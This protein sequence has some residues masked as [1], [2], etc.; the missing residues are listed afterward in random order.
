MS[1]VISNIKLNDDYY[2]IKV[3]KENKSTPGQFY[4]L[5]SWEEYPVLS[6]PLSVYDSD[7]N[8]LT[9]LYKVIGEGTELLTAAKAGEEIIVEGPFGKGFPE[10]KG[11][12]AMVGGGVGIAPLYYA[13]RL[14]KEKGNKVDIY[15]SLRDRAILEKELADVCDNLVLK[16]NSRVHE[17]VNFED[18]D[19]IFT[20]GPDGLMK[21]LYNKSIGTDTKVYVSTE[22]RM[23]CGFGV[24]YVCT[25][26]TSKGN[27]LTCKDGPVFYGGDLYD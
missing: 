15:F 25:C 9:F 1:K 16:V 5:R 17:L 14:N 24:C 22:Q 2:L 8:T 6:R 10:V 12:I 7:P 26:K 23:G 27:L 11:R 19:Y 21:Y 4:M 3:S 18:Y 13:S 20:C